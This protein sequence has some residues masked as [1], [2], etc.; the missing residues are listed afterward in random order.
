MY[1]LCLF[2]R[3]VE[4]LLQRRQRV[5]TKAIPTLSRPSHS[6]PTISPIRT[7]SHSSPALQCRKTITNSHNP[8]SEAVQYSL[9]YTPIHQPQQVVVS[10]LTFKPYTAA[11]PDPAMQALILSSTYHHP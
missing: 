1:S 10:S 7:L 9:A 3:A 8:H 2:A 4:A 11:C 5:I 6:S